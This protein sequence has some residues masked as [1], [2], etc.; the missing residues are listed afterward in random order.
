[1]KLALHIRN[2]DESYFKSNF[3][4]DVSRFYNGDL[5]LEETAYQLTSCSRIYMGD[6]FCFHRLPTM[7]EIKKLCW[8]S[9][10]HGLGVTFL[11]PPMTDLHINKCKSLF[12]HIEKAFPNSEIV[13]NDWGVLFYL[14]INYPRL[15]VSAGRLLNKGFKDPRFHYLENPD[16][17]SDKIKD[18][19]ENSTFTDEKFLAYLLK[20]GVGRIE[21]DIMPSVTRTDFSDFKI[22]TSVYFPFGYVTTGR[23]CQTASQYRHGRKKFL[24]TKKCAKHCNNQTMELF[25][26]SFKLKLFQNGN[27]IYYLYEPSVLKNLLSM[28]AGGSFRLVYQG[29][30]F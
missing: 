5:S 29:F 16:S 25:H 18:V 27:T 14:K 22:K 28:N 6:E 7:D 12:S 8:F 4:Q 9:E 15:T 2:P 19:L 3:L 26:E 21:C 24:I 11:T 30:A 17:L 1:M 13:A 20:Q 23:I 10:T